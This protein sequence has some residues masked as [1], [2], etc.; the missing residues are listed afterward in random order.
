[1]G[2][3]R[4][5][6][7][8]CVIDFSFQLTRPYGARLGATYGSS[9][10]LQFQPTRPYWAR[11][12]GHRVAERFQQRFNPR[13]PMGRDFRADA[14]RTT[15]TAFQPTRPY[16]AR[17]A[18]DA[19]LSKAGVFQPTR[20][21]GARLPRPST[22]VSICRRFQPTRPYGARH[23][24][25]NQRRDLASSFNP[26]APMGRDERAADV[27]LRGPRFQP[28][29]PYG[30]RQQDTADGNRWLRVSTHAPLW[31]ATRRSAHEGIPLAGFNPRA[32]MG[33][34]AVLARHLGNQLEFQPTRP[35]G[36]RRRTSIP[37]PLRRCFNPRAP[38][39][40][41]GGSRKA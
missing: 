24:R 25:R 21:Y 27:L 26:R 10:R 5:S 20:P 8:T 32:P 38:M 16:G 30:A 23:A 12:L 33:R 11:P 35:Y 7:S 31:G 19:K 28:T 4:R 3:D 1:M 15:L 2:R 39:G 29:R 6:P 14:R 40:R 41:D 34:D 18:V 36:A 9:F 22:L 17:R 37:T 13:A